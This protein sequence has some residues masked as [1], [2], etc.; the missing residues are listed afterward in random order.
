MTINQESYQS[1]QT[2]SDSR[3]GIGSQN[4]ELNCDEVLRL[5]CT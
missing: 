1:E 2:E 4:R 3:V 5:E